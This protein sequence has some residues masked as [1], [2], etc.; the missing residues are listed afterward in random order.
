[1][2]VIL[3][4]SQ[5]SMD[6]FSSSGAMARKNVCICTFQKSLNGF[7]TETSAVRATH[8]GAGSPCRGE[9]IAGRLCGRVLRSAMGFQESKRYGILKNWVDTHRMHI[10][11]W[12]SYHL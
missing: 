6:G 11:N 4:F 3:E 9:E 10:A 7:E 2:R 8:Y 1:M 5:T 12:V